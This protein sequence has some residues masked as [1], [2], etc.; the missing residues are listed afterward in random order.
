MPASFQK[1]VGDDVAYTQRVVSWSKRG[2]AFFPSLHLLHLHLYLPT[3]SIPLL[4]LEKV[5]PSLIEGLFPLLSVPY[6]TLW[7]L[8]A[9]PG[10]YRS[11]KFLHWGPTEVQLWSE[12]MLCL[13]FGAWVTSLSTSQAHPFI[14]KFII[15][16]LF[17]P[18]WNPIVY[19]YHNFIIHESVDGHLGRSTSQLL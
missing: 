7:T 16:S 17:V 6:L 1:K 9:F 19:M 4:P 8:Q 2:A 15:S 12:N 5:F 10:K 13:S 3:P 11:L 14:W 18:K